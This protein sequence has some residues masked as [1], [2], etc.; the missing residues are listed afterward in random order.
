MY[1]VAAT[2]PASIV[3]ALTQPPSTA[4]NPNSPKTT[5]CPRV[6]L[7]FIRPL[8]LFR[9][10]T[11]LG[12]SAIGLV[13]V[14]ALVNPHLDANIA[15]GSTGLH[16]TV[17]DFRP[18]C[19]ERNRPHRLLFAAGHFRPTEPA[20]QLHLNAFGAS[21][22]RRF[23]STLERAT[24]TRSLGELLCNFFGHKMSLYLGP[25]NFFDLN[26]DAAADQVLQ[27]ILQLIDLLPL[28]ANDDARPG[29]VKNNLHFITGAL[30]FN[31]GDPRKLVF[32]RHVLT[33]LVI[34]QQKRSK[35]FLRG[36]PP[37]FPA[38]HDA[39][40]KTNWIDL[41][42]HLSFHRDRNVCTATGD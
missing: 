32:L 26:I 25:C 1:C 6:A 12:I 14:H 9:C 20:S 31:L 27:F 30:D 40:A 39:R 18:Q 38:D 17:I 42:T 36:I 13:L 23:Q 29:G 24:E 35:L 8:W 5:R 28:S 41:L 21:F 37:A 11:R 2:R 16:K 3:W 22:H 34:F 4:C 15:L 33:D 7:P 10:F 19:A